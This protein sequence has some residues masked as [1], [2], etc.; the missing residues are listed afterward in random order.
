MGITCKPCGEW[1][2]VMKKLD[3]QLEKEA[4]LAKIAK[5]VRKQTKAEKKN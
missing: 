1:K 4:I 5:E 3:N 2:S